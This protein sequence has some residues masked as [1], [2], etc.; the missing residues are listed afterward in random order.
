MRK[1]IFISFVA[2]GAVLGFLSAL[3][4]EAGLRIV[5]T[6]FGALV[7]TAIGGALSSVGSGHRS[8]RLGGNPMPGLGTSSEDLAANYWRDKGHPPFM[9]P[10]TAEPDRH[11]FDPDRLD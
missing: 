3:D 8:V 2:L 1:L 5:M 7:G 6:L 4:G 11:M 9:K 10:S